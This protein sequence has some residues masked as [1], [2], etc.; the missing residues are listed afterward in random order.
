MVVPAKAGI[1]LRR[2]PFERDPIQ[3]LY[4]PLVRKPG[5]FLNGIPAFAGTTTLRAP[6]FA[7]TTTLR[8][9]DISGIR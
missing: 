1:Q 7:G 5:D 6:A 8:L 4:S 9:L 3:P 2:D